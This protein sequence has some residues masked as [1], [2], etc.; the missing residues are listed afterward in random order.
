M[1]ILWIFFLNNIFFF[2]FFY[3]YF[4]L[5]FLIFIFAIFIIISII[6]I[7][8]IIIIILFDWQRWATIEEIQGSKLREIELIGKKI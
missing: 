1:I 8:I 2:Q 4:L 6:I 3:F 5:F 7:I